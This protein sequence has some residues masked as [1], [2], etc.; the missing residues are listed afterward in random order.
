LGLRAR[1][2]IYVGTWWIQHLVPSRSGQE[3]SQSISGAKA[4]REWHSDRNRW[5]SLR[6]SQHDGPTTCFRAQWNGGHRY[7]PRHGQ[8]SQQGF[9]RSAVQRDDERADVA[10]VPRLQRIVG[11]MGLCTQRWRTREQQFQ[12]Q[13]RI[14][15]QQLAAGAFPLSLRLVVKVKGRSSGHPSVCVRRMKGRASSSVSD[16]DR[17]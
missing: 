10:S 5:P 3:P 16:F 1:L 13:W 7:T 17:S 6:R 4:S 14:I 11:C 9:T 15:A 12:P 8:Q 2:R